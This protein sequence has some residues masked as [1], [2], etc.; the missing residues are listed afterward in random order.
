MA[1]D[2][3]GDV[4]S[5][6]IFN[7]QGFSLHD[8]P[9]IRMLVFLKG[10]PLRCKWCSNPESQAQT[11]E[12]AFNKQRCIGCQECG[13]CINACTNE[14]V[15]SSDDGKISIDRTLCNDCG[16]CAVVCPSKA[17][18]LFG[19][20]IEARDLLEIIEADGAFYRRSGGGVTLSGGDPILQADFARELLKSCKEIGI[21]TAVETAG[22]GPWD[23]LEKLCRY[24]DTIIFDIKLPDAERHKEYTGVSNDLILRNL[25]KIDRHFPQKTLIVRT[26]IIPDVNDNPEDIKAIA[27]HLKAI[28]SLDKYELLSYHR[29]GESKYYQLGRKYDFKD[30][31]PPSEKKMKLLQSVA[32]KLLPN[33]GVAFS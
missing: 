7:T 18:N 19:E 29:F 26:P 20:S 33:V 23:D 21:H 9:G 27:S 3:I 31:I 2:R 25:K 8:G 28:G 15:R 12:I 5:G 4:Q 6:L 22:Y 13:L 10:C 11:P 17:L 14:A 32:K 24:A 16:A 30:A 1:S